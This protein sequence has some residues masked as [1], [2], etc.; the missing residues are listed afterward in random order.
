MAAITEARLRNMADAAYL[1]VELY[2]ARKLLSKGIGRGWRPT[3]DR[4]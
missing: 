2:V 4:Q 1:R 3:F